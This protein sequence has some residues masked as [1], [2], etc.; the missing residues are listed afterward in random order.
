ML[1]LALSCI[2]QKHISVDKVNSNWRLILY[3]SFE[4]CTSTTTVI[5]WGV[6]FEFR[7][8]VT[9][10]EE[11]AWQIPIP[12]YYKLGNCTCLKHFLG[13]NSVFFFYYGLF[14]KTEMEIHVAQKIV[15][16]KCSRTRKMPGHNMTFSVWCP[17]QSVSKKITRIFGTRMFPHYI[18][19]TKT[20]KDLKSAI[21]LVFLVYPNCLLT[22]WIWSLGNH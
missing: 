5:K 8:C 16:S 10:R 14:K 6:N 22:I 3:M 21:L 12:S 19:G 20:N 2:L 11:R 9:I 7:S 18:A 17:N 15:S 13:L 4:E 1:N